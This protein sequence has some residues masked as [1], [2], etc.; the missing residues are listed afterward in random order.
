MQTF[1]KFYF[2]KVNLEANS[3]CINKF[4]LEDIPFEI[5]LSTVLLVQIA[6]VYNNKLMNINS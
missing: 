2:I 1:I 6:A 5:T 4:L 3:I